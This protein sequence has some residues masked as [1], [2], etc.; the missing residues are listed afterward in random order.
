M[1]WISSLFTGTSFAVLGAALAVIF[2]GMGSSKGVGLA[3][4][5]G[6]GILTE[7]PTKFGKVLL[8]QALPGTQGIYGL[9]VAF[10]ILF[11]NGAVL[12]GTLPLVQGVAY[13]FAALPT[14]IV[15]YYS[16]I[17]QGRVAAMNIVAKKPD[18]A[19]KGVISAGLVETYAVL[20][21][22]ISVLVIFGVGSMAA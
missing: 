2:A 3:G 4:E 1:E 14:A 5:A 18:D 13:F 11:S 19:M 20:A 17:R 6:T 10:L 12:D 21:L 22:L 9:L 15:G 7:D 16:A 8:L